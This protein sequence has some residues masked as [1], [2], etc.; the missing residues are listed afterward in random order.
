MVQTRWT[1]LNRDY[2]FLTQVEAILLDGHFVLEHGGALARRR[3]LQFQRHRRHVAAQ[4]DRRSR[5]LAARHADR[6]HRP[7]LSR[8]AQ[9]LAVQISAGRR[10]PGRAADRDDRLQDPAG[11][12]GQGADPDHQRRF[13]RTSSAADVPFHIKI[14]AF[15]HLTANIS[16]PLMI[17]LSTAADAGHDHPLLSGLVPDAAD[18]RAAL[19][20]RPPFPS[21]P[22]IWSPRRSCFPDELVSRRFSICRS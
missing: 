13:C 4:A 5:R 20:W 10:M 22:F 7:E 9:R 6:R 8:A 3:L 12:L 16:Y 21:P 2:S 19:S 18:R 17:V 15:Y 14:E 1:H 11:A